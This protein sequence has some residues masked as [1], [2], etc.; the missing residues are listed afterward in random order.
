M[1][2]EREEQERKRKPINELLSRTLEACESAGIQV[3]V[4]S[5]GSTP[6]AY[7]AHEFAGVNEIRPGV[8]I[9]NDRNMLGL[10]VVAVEDCALSIVAT[11]ASTAVSGKAI[12]DG[13]SKT[14]SSD[15][16]LAGDGK[17]F[18]LIKGDADAQLEAMS[19]EHGNLNISRSSVRY[20]PGDRIE[21]IPNHVCSVVNMHD[22][23]YGVRGDRV[24]TVFE[25]AARGALR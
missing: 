1:Q 23:I 17:G 16:Y 4:V 15:R 13:G 12:I 5:G 3:A 20:R 22:E 18:G 21:I 11:V 14:F 19:E 24:E 10:G 25:V 8:Y 7:L 6:T 2:V 9:F